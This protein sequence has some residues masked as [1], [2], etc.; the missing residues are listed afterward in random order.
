MTLRVHKTARAERD[1]DQ[2]TDWIARDNEIAAIKWLSELDEKLSIIA[3]SPGIGTDR[4]N[5]RPGV[6]S[7]AFGNY[8]IFFKVNK[9]GVVVLR[10]I[11]GARDYPAFFK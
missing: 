6:R 5:L 8:L 1:I 3:Q 7:Y 4:S 9:S 10:I 11:H 2:I